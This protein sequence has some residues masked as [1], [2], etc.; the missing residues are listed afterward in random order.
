MILQD[1]G[2]DEERHYEALH[3]VLLLVLYLDSHVGTLLD[4]VVTELGVGAKL[5][6]VYRPKIAKNEHSIY[7]N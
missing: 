3:S 7:R 5:V 1:Y 4:F 2:P 6:P